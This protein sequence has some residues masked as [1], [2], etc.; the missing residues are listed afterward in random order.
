MER[1]IFGVL[2]VLATTVFLALPTVQAQS[3]LIA[4]VPFDFHVGKK[5][6]A[7]GSY[8][9]LCMSEQ[10]DLVNDMDTGAAAFV[11]KAIHIQ[12]MHD[13]DAK[14]VFNKYGNQSFLSQIWDGRSNVG[15]ELPKSKREKELVLAAKRTHGSETITV[16]MK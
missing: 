8:E 10:V 9:V 5:A 13:E 12:A 6:M 2:S 14:L 16:A 1:K 15:I 11:V 7:A 3:R 4:N